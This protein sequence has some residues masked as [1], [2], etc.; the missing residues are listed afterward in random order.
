MSVAQRGHRPASSGLRA[1]GQAIRRTWL[2]YW[3]RGMANLHR[4]HCLWWPEHIDESRWSVYPEICWTAPQN[5]HCTSIGHSLKRCISYLSPF[6]KLGS[7]WPQKPQRL[8]WPE[9]GAGS[10][11]EADFPRLLRFSV[12][13]SRTRLS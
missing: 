10:A 13:L 7:V 11:L 1:G 12:I 3:S 4:G 2:S 9:V 6:W 5:L 8:D